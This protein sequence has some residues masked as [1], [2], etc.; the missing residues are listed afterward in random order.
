MRLFLFILLSPSF[1]NAEDLSKSI[2]IIKKP[3]STDS[4]A[5]TIVGPRSVI[6]PSSAVAGKELVFEGQVYKIRGKLIGSN[7]F[8]SALMWT[9]TD[10]EGAEPVHIGNPLHRKDPLVA[11]SYDA[12]NSDSPW[13]RNEIR[14]TGFEDV[15]FR[16]AFKS[17][18][19]LP[20]HI[21]EPIFAEKNGEKSLAG[22]T[23]T[24]ITTLERD[25]FRLDYPIL[26]A[27]LKKVA[28]AN[29][30]EVCGVNLV[31]KTI[32]DVDPIPPAPFCQAPSVS[33]TSGTPITF[34][35]AYQ[36]EVTQIEILGQKVSLDKPQLTIPMLTDTVFPKFILIPILVRGPGGSCRSMN[37][38]Y[39]KE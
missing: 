21:S 10:I 11:L 33:I 30:V 9:E 26:L 4:F 2:A 22:V 32:S 35:A 31:C 3:S 8:Y 28:E 38:Y 15:V 37:Q 29:G 24:T 19:S 14:V 1:I 13:K 36:G 6:A 34:S 5:A 12:S 7:L 20:L 39:V 25:A 18:T 17:S 23:R 27:G 16:Y